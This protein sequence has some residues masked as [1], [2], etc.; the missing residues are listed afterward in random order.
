MRYTA[1]GNSLEPYAYLRYL[2]TQLPATK[3]VDDFEALLPWNIEKS[4]SGNVDKYVH[5]WVLTKQLQYRF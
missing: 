4:D 1:S 3:S 2:F 5:R